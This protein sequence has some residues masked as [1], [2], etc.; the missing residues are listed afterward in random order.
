MPMGEYTQWGKYFFPLYNNNN[1]DK[2]N[3]HYTFNK[4]TGKTS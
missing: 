2:E 4:T 3:P 1:K